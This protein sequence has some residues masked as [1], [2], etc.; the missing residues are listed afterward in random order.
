MIRSVAPIAALALLIAAV[1]AAAQ[2]RGQTTDQLSQALGGGQPNGASTNPVMSNDRRYARVIAFESEAT[3]LVSGDTNGAKDVFM[4]QRDGSFGNDGSR[5]DLGG[6]RLLSKAANGGPADGPSYGPAV[7]GSFANDKPSCVAFVSEAT[8]LVSGDSNGSPDA[9]VSRGPGGSLSKLS[10]KGGVTQV[11]VS[12]DCSRIAF[13]EGGRVKVRAGSR[14]RDLGRGSDPSF[15][16]G[17]TNDLVFTG[18]RGVRLSTDGTGSPKLVASGGRNPGYNDVKCQVVTY[19]K[20]NQ[21]Y[22]RRIGGASNCGVRSGERLVSGRDGQ[23]GN[24]ASTNPVIGNSGFYVSFESDATNLGVNANG[25][26]GDGNGQPDVYLYTESRQIT[27]VQSVERLGV[28]LAGGGGRPSMS[29]Y[30]NYIVFASLVNG[31]PQILMRYLGSV[32]EPTRGEA[33]SR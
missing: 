1:P 31:T 29:Y 28:P 17:Q 9:F 6:T 2:D 10:T 7:D 23:E 14:L 20:G 11:A 15:A 13:T 32:E 26:T 18:S 24:G 3:N 4:I 25:E 19:E 12:G 5:W 33:L 30:A 21:V 22:F 16:T 27:L 8:N